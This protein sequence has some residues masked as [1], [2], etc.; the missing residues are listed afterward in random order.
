MAITRPDEYVHQNQDLA[1]ADSRNVRGGRRAAADRAALY[2]LASK[3][4]QLT[5]NVTIVRLLSDGENGG[6]ITEVVLVDIANIGS[7]AGWQLYNAGG[8]G[9]GGGGSAASYGEYT[10]L[11]EADGP[12]TIALPAGALGLD[13]Q[14]TWHQADTG[15][16]DTLGNYVF[17]DGGI[18]ILDGS[19]VKAGDKIYGRYYYGGT[20]GPGGK[21]QASDIVGKLSPEQ[22]PDLD[23][24]DLQLLAQY[25]QPYLDQRYVQR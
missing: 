18:E 16:G 25:L 20:P 13:G 8:S 5:E 19:P 2:A 6:G 15:L 11:L 12:Q 22:A 1:I 14:P 3:S 4:D 21:V 10:I 24:T 7:P 9:S 17:A 23:D